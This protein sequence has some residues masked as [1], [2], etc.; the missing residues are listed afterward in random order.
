MD[1]MP[2][3]DS[4][5]DRPQWQRIDGQEAGQDMAVD[6]LLLRCYG[7]GDGMVYVESRDLR[8]RQ[9]KMFLLFPKRL[10]LQSNRE[11]RLAYSVAT[12]C[13]LDPI[14]LQKHVTDFVLRAPNKINYVFPEI[15]EH[16]FRTWKNKTKKFVQPC[17]HDTLLAVIIFCLD[18]TKNNMLPAP[19]NHQQ[20]RD[21]IK[22]FCTTNLHSLRPDDFKSASK[23][24][25]IQYGALRVI[26]TKERLRPF[27]H[28]VFGG[29]ELHRA[30]NM[31]D[32]SDCW[33]RYLAG[34]EN[35][36]PL[37]SA[38]G[39]FSLAL[40]TQRQVDNAMTTAA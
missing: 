16:R 15:Y 12:C 11:S 5:V 19:K 14:N 18:G 24:E 8:E 38:L 27:D 36:E 37:S 33:K 34:I 32:R 30:C 23:V 4:G 25:F 17:I 9:N 31:L 28:A 7:G 1:A 26:W 21:F 39:L 10:C 2:A 22:D 3:D 20:W 40:T 13:T 29:L 6:G 35:K